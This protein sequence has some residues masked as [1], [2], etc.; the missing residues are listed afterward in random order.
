MLREKRNANDS[1]Q[2]ESL[3]YVA[4]K[5]QRTPIASRSPT[6]PP[7]SATEVFRSVFRGGGS[8]GGGGGS[9]VDWQKLFRNS[10]NI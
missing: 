3:S 5:F 2:T 4:N 1:F 7:R 10:L 9:E 6:A 8:G